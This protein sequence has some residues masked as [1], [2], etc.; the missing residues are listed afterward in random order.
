M[1]ID[2]A[3]VADEIGIVG[4][5]LQSLV[6]LTDGNVRIS[7]LHL[8]ET[9]IVMEVGI[10]GRCG[11]RLLKRCDRCGHVSSALRHHTKALLQPGNRRISLRGLFVMVERVNR[12]AVI[13]IQ[14]SEIEVRKRIV[15]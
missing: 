10:L 15:E 4:T 11:H 6:E 12:T 2:S 7:A 5:D 3:Q 14:S 8:C 9:E 1:Q 13:F